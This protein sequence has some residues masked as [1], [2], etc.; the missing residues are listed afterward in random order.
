MREVGGGPA[1]GVRA[2]VAGAVTLA[3]IAGAARAADAAALTMRHSSEPAVATATIPVPSGWRVTGEGRS[4]ATV[5]APTSRARCSHK[6]TL[7]LR[8]FAVAGSASAPAWI[9]ARLQHQGPALGRGGTGPTAWGAARRRRSPAAIGV[10]ARIDSSGDADA[11]LAELL[12]SAKPTSGC[13]KREPRAMGRRLTRLLSGV[14]L[15]LQRE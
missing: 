9:D 12:V 8:S 6:L 2:A 15:A 3:A 5:V 4:R 7:S 10:V 13:S 1:Q 11:L 14:A